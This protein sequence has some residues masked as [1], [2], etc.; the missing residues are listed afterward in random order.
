MLLKAKLH[1]LVP[2]F[3]LT[4]GCL[5]KQSEA[6]PHA[7]SRC[8]ETDC[9]EIRAWI[10]RPEKSDY[11]CWYEGIQGKVNGLGDV[12]VLQH[13]PVDV[14]IANEMFKE[15]VKKRADESGDWGMT[16]FGTG[17]AAGL[18]FLLGCGG[19][20][21]VV[22]GFVAVGLAG[23]SL[24]GFLNSEEARG[25]ASAGRELAQN[26]GARQV[27]NQSQRVAVGSWVYD[28]LKE[29]YKEAATQ[30]TDQADI[31]SCDTISPD[32]LKNIFKFI[33][34]TVGE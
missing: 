13:R 21:G 8:A 6:Q 12:K 5:R 10:P 28:A 27:A 22:C 1:L 24:G 2:V 7:V 29:S 23:A 34:T 15:K 32:A 9:K 19:P 20:Q 31:Y 4:A 18:L 25:Q 33:G 17:T 3:L 26:H 14:R 30:T 11:Q 16:G